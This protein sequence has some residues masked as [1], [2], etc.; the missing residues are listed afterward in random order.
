MIQRRRTADDIV[1]RQFHPFPDEETVV[2]D[3]PVCQTGRL[4]RRCRARRKLNIH[5]IIHV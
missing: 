5:D 1:L 2:Q 4:G 3:V